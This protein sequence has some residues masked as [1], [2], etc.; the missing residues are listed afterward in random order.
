[1]FS[2][3][4]RLRSLLVVAI[5]L[6]KELSQTFLVHDTQQHIVMRMTQHHCRFTVTLLVIITLIACVNAQPQGYDSTDGMDWSSPL[7][8]IGGQFF[9]MLAS[10]PFPQT[11]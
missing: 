2:F 9:D 4:H 3:H 8:G 11:V 1:M 7:S 6:S 5:S 10:V